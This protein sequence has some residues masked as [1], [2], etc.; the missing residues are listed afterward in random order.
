M[1]CGS[2]LGCSCNVYVD[3]VRYTCDI[4]HVFAHVILTYRRVFDFTVSNVSNVSSLYFS[5][6]ER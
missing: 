1:F 2:D 6:A 3:H 4:Y 5:R